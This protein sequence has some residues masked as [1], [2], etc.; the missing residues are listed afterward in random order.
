MTL[1]HHSLLPDARLL[2]RFGKGLKR[3][4]SHHQYWRSGHQQSHYFPYNGLADP[5]AGQGGEP[6]GKSQLPRH[7]GSIIVYQQSDGALSYRIEGEA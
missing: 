2:R 4:E 6:A 1:T 3:R 7:A 5:Q